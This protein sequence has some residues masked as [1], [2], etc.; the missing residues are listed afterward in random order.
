MPAPRYDFWVVALTISVGGA[1]LL[2]QSYA[3]EGISGYFPQAVCASIVGLGIF[4]MLM[5]NL[6]RHG[7]GR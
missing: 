6:F 3:I 2:R 4:I 5:R 1:V 7:A